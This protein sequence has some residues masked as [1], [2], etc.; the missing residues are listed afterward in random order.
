M[1]QPELAR[2]LGSLVASGALLTLF[3]APVQAAPDASTTSA[4]G[5]LL[6]QATSPSPG[7]PATAPTKAR[8]P[9]RKFVEEAA[10]GGMAEVEAGKLAQKQAAAAPVKAFAEQMVADHTK[11]N[12]QLAQIAMTKGIEVPTEADRS[13]KRSL[14]KMGKLQGAEFDRE[15]MKTMVAD[16]KKTVSLFEKESKSGKD[17]ELKKFAATLL[18][19]L[20]KHLQ[21]AQTHEQEVKKSSA[22]LDERNRSGTMK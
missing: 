18:P 4:G 7:S 16:H 15:Y 21:M 20:Q 10:R 2:G 11:A 12:D 1:K 14:E 5:I 17:P 6:A 13:H 19:D 3:A 9:D 8:N 22:S